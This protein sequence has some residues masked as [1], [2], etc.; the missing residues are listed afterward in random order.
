MSAIGIVESGEFKQYADSSPN[1]GETPIDFQTA[2]QLA[3]VE[4]GDSISVALGKLS[5]L[6][7]EIEKSA[8]VKNGPRPIINN[9]DLNEYFKNPD[10][11]GSWCLRNV[12]STSSV[13]APVGGYTGN[14]DVCYTIGVDNDDYQR[15]TFVPHNKNWIATRYISGDSADVGKFHPWDYFYPN[16]V[17]ITEG[18]VDLDTFKVTGNYF[19][20][21][22]SLKGFLEVIVD[23]TVPRV[24]QRFTWHSN[25]GDSY[26][27][28]W[29]RTYVNGRWGSWKHSYGS[30]W[31]PFEHFYPTDDVWFDAFYTA[32]NAAPEYKKFD[33]DSNK[34]HEG[35][36][37]IFKRTNNTNCHGIF[38]PGASSKTIYGIAGFPSNRKSWELQPLTS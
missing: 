1:I 34:S 28:I 19:I 13:N 18:D 3:N 29:F 23:P 11:V 30:G 32:I 15:Q 25:S 6:Y 4:S 27:D 2:T 31:V 36:V 9:E 22:S 33:F 38:V 21:A 12:T 14:L 10:K 8:C 5:K 16:G 37:T 26:G 17:K 20:D 35:F 24:L 7:G